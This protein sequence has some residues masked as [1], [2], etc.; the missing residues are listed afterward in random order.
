M[1]CTFS[2]YIVGVGKMTSIMI[3]EK[4]R[5]ISR[6]FQWRPYLPHRISPFIALMK[7]NLYLEFNFCLKASLNEK[8]IRLYIL[9]WIFPKFSLW[10]IWLLLWKWLGF[11][12]A[13]SLRKS[14]SSIEGNFLHLNVMTG[15]KRQALQE[16]SFEVFQDAVIKNSKNTQ[17]QA[18]W[19]WECFRIFKKIKQNTNQKPFSLSS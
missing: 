1:S 9:M 11:F 17:K 8:K 3:V 10:Y 19:I 6:S 12:K 15:F 5:D 7:T 2:P 16:G 4:A 14:F 18:H 13:F